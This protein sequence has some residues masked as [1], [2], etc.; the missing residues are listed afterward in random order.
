[1]AVKWAEAL[2]MEDLQM[3]AAPITARAT[4]AATTASKLAKA[5]TAAG[6]DLRRVDLRDRV[7]ASKVDK[8]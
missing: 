2:L 7:A 8:V 5:S 4:M 6:M 3:V 1:V